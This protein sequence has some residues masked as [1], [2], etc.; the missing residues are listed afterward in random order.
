M[1]L[2]N[3]A[4]PS[5]YCL[6]IPNAS[7]TFRQPKLQQVFQTSDDQHGL[8]IHLKL[9]WPHKLAKEAGAPSASWVVLHS[10]PD[11]DKLHMTVVVQNKTATR[12]PEALWLRFKPGYGA[13]DEESWVM[14]K[15]DGH[16][17]PQEVKM[18]ISRL[19]PEVPPAVQNVVLAARDP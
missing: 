16:V 8:M 12:L 3:Y 18:L 9:T 15:L 1:L 13:V 5:A 4:L 6:I 11:T 19:S 17:K 2:S 7:R 14:H 10:P